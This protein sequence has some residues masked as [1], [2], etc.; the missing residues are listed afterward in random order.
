MKWEEL[1]QVFDVEAVK[2]RSEQLFSYEKRC[3]HSEFALG[4]KYCASAL[5]E[6]GFEQVEILEHPADGRT[7]YFDGTMPPAWDLCG[8]SVLRIAGEDTI[9]ADTDVAPFVAAPWSA[10]TPKGGVEGELIVVSPGEMPDVRGKW[11]LIVIED[12]RNPAG[13]YLEQLSL[14]GAIGAVA[15]NRR[16]K[17]KYPDSVTWFNGT[18]KFGWYPVAGDHRIPLF[19]ISCHCAEMLQKRLAAGPIWLHGE[20]D[21]R[22]S[23]GKVYTVTAVIPGESEQEYVL[24]SHM[25]EPFVGDN[26]FGFGA[27]CEIG[28]AIRA[29]C[30]RPQKTLRVAFSMEFY[31]FSAFLAEDA[32]AKKILGALNMDALNHRFSRTLNFRLSPLSC[33]WFGDWLLY[34][35]YLKADPEAQYVRTAGNLSDDTFMGDA[36]FR[37]FPVNWLYNPSGITH[38]CGCDGFEPDWQ[39]AKQQLPA[40]A[41]AILA[42]LECTPES[43]CDFEAA[44]EEELKKQVGD[45]LEKSCSAREKKLLLSGAFSYQKGRLQSA[46]NYCG[47]TFDDG[48]L[49]KIHQAACEKVGGEDFFSEAEKQAD[50]LTPLRLK[51]TPFSLADIPYAERKVFRASRLL[52]ALLDGKRTLWEAIRLSDWALNQ[53]SSDEEI[54]HQI[55]L[56]QYLARYQYIRL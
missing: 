42:M 26:A 29:V 34:G 46:T 50:K 53:R 40:L 30:P 8:R 36:M 12:G 1:R 3:S 39:W 19:S 27:V 15:V 48:A 13:V 31:G 47:A 45:I 14:H 11:V 23:E 38:H 10:P 20:M 54:D 35:E 49:T 55:E 24:F 43:C 32:R 2:Y 6:A 28:K 37:N 41:S 51:P 4:A 52:F 44:A 25:D 21:C 33:P 7:S 22:I 17:D 16:L 18:G 56:L 9:L 5:K